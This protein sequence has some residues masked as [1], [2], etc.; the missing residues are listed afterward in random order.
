MLQHKYGLM[1]SFL[2]WMSVYKPL[3]SVLIPSHRQKITKDG[4]PEVRSNIKQLEAVWDRKWM[5]TLTD[6]PLVSFLNE[7]PVSIPLGF[8][9]LFNHRLAAVSP[10]SSAR[11]SRQTSIT[12]LS[13]ATHSGGS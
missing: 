2:R 6:T 8:L 11:N 3:T 7:D 12:L 5:D 4:I 1:F 9:N 13:L 10:I